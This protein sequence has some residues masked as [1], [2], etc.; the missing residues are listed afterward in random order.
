MAWFWDAYLPD[1]ST[2]AEITAS[3]LRAGIDQLTGLPEAFVI[4]DENDVLRLPAMYE[5]RLQQV[6]GSG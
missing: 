6:S 5:R 1:R 2:R 4:V 3:P